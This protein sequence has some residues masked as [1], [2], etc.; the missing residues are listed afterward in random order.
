M[1]ESGT[2]STYEEDMFVKIEKIE[3]PDGWL[4]SEPDRGSYGAAGY[5]LSSSSRDV[6]VCLPGQRVLV[7][8][9]LK[10][11]LP[12]GC[13]AQIRS[14]SGLALKKGVMV[15]NSPGTVD[16]DYRGEIGVI[17]MNFGSEP[18]VIN[19]GDRIAQM[20]IAR[21]ERVKFIDS[22]LD[23]TLRADAGFGSTGTKSFDG[24]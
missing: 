14:R 17:L 24:T 1:A 23:D 9:G 6:I 7:P 2:R 19:R 12:A 8:T 16:S 5:D 15:L 21:H 20:V 13:E 11:S 18:F 22:I 4:P 10:I 3:Q